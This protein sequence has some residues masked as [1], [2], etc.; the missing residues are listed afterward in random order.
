MILAAPIS[1]GQAIMLGLLQGVAEL[2]PISSLGQSVIAAARVRLGHPPERHYFIAF[3]VATH[4]ATAIVLLGF[5]WRD[6]VRILTGM[7]RS[8]QR[9]RRSRRATPTAGS[10]G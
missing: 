4:L 5:F 6:W 8:L 2:F 10:A 3:L 1:Y 9:A 7:W